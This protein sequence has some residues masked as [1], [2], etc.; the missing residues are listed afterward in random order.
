MS[1]TEEKIR[2]CEHKIH[3]RILRKHHHLQL[4]GR[5]RD[6]EEAKRL[7]EEVTRLKKDKEFISK[8]IQFYSYDKERNEQ[9]SASIIEELQSHER[10]K[11][12]L[13]QRF[14]KLNNKLSPLE[15]IDKELEKQLA[16]LKA[17]IKSQKEGLINIKHSVVSSVRTF[18]TDEG[19]QRI[20]TEIDRFAEEWPNEVV[21][22]EPQ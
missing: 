1:G 5:D 16:P 2:T 6:M 19:M 10:E 18:S 4:F 14:K 8:A 12:R 11:A 15:V 3:H 13:T 7:Q 22:A 17:L 20:L 21:N 9:T